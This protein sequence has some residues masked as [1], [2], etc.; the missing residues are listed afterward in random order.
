[1]KKNA[2]RIFDT[3]FRLLSSN[4]PIAGFKLTAAVLANVGGIGRHLAPNGAAMYSPLPRSL[5]SV[6]HL[7]LASKWLLG[8][9]RVGSNRASVSFVLN[10][11]VELD[12]IDNSNGGFLSKRF[13]C[14]TIVELRLT[15]NG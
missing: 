4:N 12:N 10:H 9:K 7:S 14:A 11:V 13:S 6:P 5:F 2:K 15:G 1:M 8:N 3:S